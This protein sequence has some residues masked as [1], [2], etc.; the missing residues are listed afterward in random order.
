MDPR[1]YHVTNVVLQALAAVAFFFFARALFASCASLAAARGWKLDVAAALA[2]LAFAVHPLRVE[3]VAWVTERRDVLSGLF[4]AL[5]CW[6]Y[7]RFASATGPAR[8]RWFVAVHVSFAA[9]LAAKGL[10]FPLPL[11]LLVL[12]ALVLGRWNGTLARVTNEGKRSIAALAREKAG[13]FA[14]A[15]AAAVVAWVGQSTH[16]SVRD[17]EAHGMGVRIGQAFYALYFYVWKTLVPLDLIPLVPLPQEHDDVPAKFALAIAVVIAAAVAVWLLRRRAPAL[18]A[19]ALAYA[20]LLAPV[21]GLAQAGPQLV[22][23]RYSY[24]PCMPLALVFGAGLL[25]L[26]LERPALA[27]WGWCLA[28]LAVL[29]L[30]WLTRVQSSVWR[31][32]VSLWTKTVA[33]RP[34]DAPAFRNLYLAWSRL[35]EAE[36]DPVRARTYFERALFECR[37][38]LMAGPDAGL[39]SNA[40][41]ASREIAFLDVEHKQAHLEAS[42]EYAQRAVARSLQEREPTKVA[43]LNL[44]FTLLDLGRPGDAVAP[45]AWLADHDPQDPESPF[46][47]AQTLSMAGRPRDALLAYDAALQLAPNSPRVWMEK[48]LAHA[49]LGE[50]PNA[51]ASMERALKLA[52]LL[53]PEH[54]ED[55]AVVAGWREEL[56]RLQKP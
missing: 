18:A 54:A 53:P 38:G 43:W 30:V 39:L 56:Q 7:V 49:A 26:A 22:A 28:G 33:V 16:A 21:S 13:L 37:R 24:L 42:L 32:D 45:F 23:D 36:T 41:A 8:T 25:Q 34:H 9:S 15:L 46:R 35:G 55:P 48:G 10:G 4:F 3:S 47:L 6:A 31:D 2:A 14:L 44:G 1:G 27:R 29:V 50:K 52:E 11:A 40:S 51:I 5:T 19:A 12:D 20:I 17:L